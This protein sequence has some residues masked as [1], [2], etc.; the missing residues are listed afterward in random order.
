MATDEGALD[1][2]KAQLGSIILILVQALFL[3]IAWI[4]RITG[5]AKFDKI[6]QIE[7]TVKLQLHACC[8]LFVAASNSVIFF[9]AFIWNP[10]IVVKAMMD[11]HWSFPAMFGMHQNDHPFSIC[12]LL[13]I[14]MAIYWQRSFLW[15]YL[16]DEA[17]K[18]RRWLQ[19]PYR[20]GFMKDE[21]V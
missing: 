17:K 14:V 7:N 5:Y 20:I 19:W 16:T 18:E 6:K 4:T 12:W 11:F 21:I 3:Y 1:M 9:G 10:L 13:G 15:R 8:V 2:R